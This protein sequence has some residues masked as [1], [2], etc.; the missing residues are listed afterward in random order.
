MKPAVKDPKGLRLN[1]A[2]TA[3]TIRLVT[4]EGKPCFKTSLVECIPLRG[5]GVTAAS[6]L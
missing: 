1:G 5:N 3:R 4:D 2:I 6:R